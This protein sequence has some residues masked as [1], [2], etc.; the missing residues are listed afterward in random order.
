MRGQCDLVRKHKIFYLMVSVDVQEQPVIE[1][2]NIIGV[3]MGRV[4]CNRAQDGQYVLFHNIQ[5]SP[6]EVKLCQFP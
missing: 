5:Q 2:K 1:P 3:D 4:K 6:G